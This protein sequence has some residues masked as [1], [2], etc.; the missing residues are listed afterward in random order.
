L[1]NSTQLDTILEHFTKAFTNKRTQL[2]KTLQ[3]LTKLHNIL[4]TLPTCKKQRFAKHQNLIYNFT[5]TK[6][7]IQPKNDITKLPTN[8]LYTT[9][10]HFLHIV[11]NTTTQHFL[12]NF[13]NNNTLQKPYKLY[14]T[15]QNLSKNTKRQKISTK[16]YTI[17]KLVHNYTT[18]NT[19]FPKQTA[20]T[21]THLYN[22][23]AKQT[24]RNSTQLYNTLLQNVTESTKLFKTVHNSAKLY[25]TFTNSTNSTQLYS[26]STQTLRN[27]TQLYQLV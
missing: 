8:T 24:I 18:L 6:N 27:Y 25:K 9:L 3:F 26:N 17:Y 21:A 7:S 23:F 20:H 12:Q 1:H 4:Q 14:T 16:F 15:R 19:T 5:K 10:R 11:S 22:T 13:T 2:Y